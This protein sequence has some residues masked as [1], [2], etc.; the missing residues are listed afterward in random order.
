M[1]AIRLSP[2]GPVI[3]NSTGGQFDPGHGAR[4]R[5]DELQSTMSPTGGGSGAV[6]TSQSVIAS[7]GFG[8]AAPLS[9]SFA[10]PKEGLKYRADLR[11]DLFNVSTSHNAVVVLF[12][13]TS[14]DGGSNWT[15]RS[16]SA[17]VIQPQLGVGAE[18]NGQARQ[19]SLSLELTPGSSLGVVDGTTTTIR[20]R[21]SAQLTTGSL[22][23]VEVSSLT[24]DGSVSGLDG[25]IHMMIEECF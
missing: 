11:L 14:I 18:D 10:S 4:L 19:A 6:P 2:S 1:T 24:S 20:F 13:E 17:H 8:G 12:L 15:T 7:D 23:D 25:T 3:A 16:K 21:P 9:L 5:L 22:G